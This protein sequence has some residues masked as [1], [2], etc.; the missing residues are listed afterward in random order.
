MLSE[1]AQNRF[2]PSPRL[3]R[4][5]HALIGVCLAVACTV[6][7]YRERSHALDRHALAFQEYLSEERAQAAMRENVEIEAIAAQLSMSISKRE[8]V[9]PVDQHDS[10][11]V[12]YISATETAARNWIALAGYWAAN[13]EYE[14][15]RL[16]YERV[17]GTYT[18][19]RYKPYRDQALEGLEELK[20]LQAGVKRDPAPD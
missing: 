15:A 10:D 3:Q 5:M 8:E 17:L 20:V 13:K 19:T 4:I 11:R 1:S 18:S 16:T 14:E 12:L 2:V 9:A 7:P 6:D